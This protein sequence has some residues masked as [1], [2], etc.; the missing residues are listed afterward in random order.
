MGEI[1]SSFFN[2]ILSETL[3]VIL[4]VFERVFPEYPQIGV[5]VAGFCALLFLFYFVKVSL[6]VA[7]K[8]AAAA[9]ICVSFVLYCMHA[10]HVLFFF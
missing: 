10:I 1:L 7:V 5:W 3:S 6:G 9:I 2:T 4:M 8:I